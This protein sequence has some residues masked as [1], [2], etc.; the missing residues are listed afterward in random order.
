TNSFYPNGVTSTC[1]VKPDATPSGLKTQRTCQPR[2]RVRDPGLMRSN[3]IR[4]IN[5]AFLAAAAKFGSLMEKNAPS[6]LGRQTCIERIALD[7]LDFITSER[8]K[9]YFFAPSS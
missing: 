2:V 4:G 8:S 6:K 5:S 9:F 7:R 1:I 3:P